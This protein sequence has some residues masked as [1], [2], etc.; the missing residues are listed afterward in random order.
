MKLTVKDIDNI[1]L[2]SLNNI[3]NTNVQ[4]QTSQGDAT[5]NA[6]TQPVVSFLDDE[7]KKEKTNIQ[8]F[9]RIKSVITD[10][11][12]KKIKDVAIKNSQ[13][14]LNQINQTRSIVKNKEEELT[15]NDGHQKTLFISAKNKEGIEDLKKQ[16]EI[17][18]SRID[19]YKKAEPV[20]FM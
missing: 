3:L 2:E 6:L 8:D 4:K 12:E 20:I 17:K 1:L 13:N 16:L 14:K 9:N 7:E 19:L 15:T 18:K 5:V 10:P 11:N